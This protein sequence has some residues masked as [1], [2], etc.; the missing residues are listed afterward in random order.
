MKINWVYHDNYDIP[1][2]ENHRFTSTKFSDLFTTLP[3]LSFN[4]YFSLKHLNKIQEAY[5]TE[6]PYGFVTGVLRLLSCKISFSPF[7]M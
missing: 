5:F 2:K 3:F 4:K 6:Q 7:F 1:L